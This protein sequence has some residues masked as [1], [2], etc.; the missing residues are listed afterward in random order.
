ML[1]S[2][3]RA[4][5]QLYI[6]LDTARSLSCYLLLKSREWD[7]LVTLVIDPAHYLDTTSGAEKFR[8]DYQAVEL[9]RKAPLETSID[10]RKAAE[11]SFLECEEKCLA[12]NTAISLIR[13]TPLGSLES[14]MHAIVQRGKRW[15]GR[16]LGPLP[17]ALP[18]RYGPGTTFELEESYFSTLMDKLSTAHAVTPACK[19]LFHFAVDGS[20]WSRIRQEKRLSLTSD[21]R[22]NRFTTVPKDG[23]TD[24][25]ICI[26]PGGNL[27]IQL[28]IGGY[29]KERLG[30]IGLYVWRARKSSP[31]PQ[32]G[33]QLVPPRPDGQEV[34]RRYAREGSIDDSWATIDLSSASD[35]VSKELVRW[36]LPPAWLELMECTRS[37]HTRFHGQWHHLHKFSSM[38][39]GFTF[40]LETL[41]FAALIHGT[42]GLSPGRDFF[43]YGDD[44][45]VP[46]AWANDTK[47]VLSAFGFHPNPRKSF[48][49][50]PFRESCGGEY[51]CGLDVNP[52]RVRGFQTDIDTLRGLHNALLRRGYVNSAKAVAEMIPR[53]Y[54][55]YG[56]ARLGDL[57]LHG[58]PARWLVTTEGSIKWLST[59]VQKANPIPIER[60]GTDFVLCAAL[61]GVKPEIGVVARSA[62][63]GLTYRRERV[64]VS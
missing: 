40:E 10:R 31:H 13:A 61:L 29:L 23:K 39:N 43:V 49:A 20:L 18:W 19:D 28:G 56:P 26:E 3:R 6:Q 54:R 57:V 59:V 47:A 50:G 53:T 44:I 8:R 21:A 1:R 38:G 30:G 16:V 62:P 4:C 25:G 46:K 36:I 5:E 12:T 34:N 17:D 64:S 58:P 15:L 60:W 22:G 7:Q 9:L 41:V 55:S 14:A 27:Y 42:T 35:T 11:A 2:Y 51:F 33:L 63:F 32:N 37:T 24:R 48:S 45:V 52:L